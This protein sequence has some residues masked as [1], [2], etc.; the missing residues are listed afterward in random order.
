VRTL[1]DDEGL[2]EGITRQGRVLKL[3]TAFKQICNHPAQHLGEPGPL[4]RPG[5]TEAYREWLAP[6]G[7]EIGQLPLGR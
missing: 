2:G 5:M 7:Q 4:R 1:L 6:R 3:L